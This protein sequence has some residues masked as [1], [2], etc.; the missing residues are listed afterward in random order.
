MAASTSY[1][2]SI[3]ASALS[4]KLGDPRPIFAFSPAAPSPHTVLA[5]VLEKSGAFCI[6]AAEGRA[7]REN[8]GEDHSIGFNWDC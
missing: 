1:D 8:R 7:D 5:R 4:I 2:L 6:H 3:V